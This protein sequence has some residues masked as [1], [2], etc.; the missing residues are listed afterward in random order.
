MAALDFPNS[1]TIGQQY[2]APNG[3]TYQWDGVVWA[4]VPVGS[5]PPSGP[6]GGDLTGSY[7]NPTIKPSALPWTPSGATLTPTDPTKNVTIPGPSGGVTGVVMGTG[8][9]K[10]RVQYSN[11]APGEFGLFVNRDWN[12]ANAQDDATRP[13][14]AFQI[15]SDVNDQLLVQRSPAG[16]TTQTALLMLD[17][18]GRLTLPGVPAPGDAFV[19]SSPSVTSGGAVHLGILNTTGGFSLRANVSL[20]NAMD[21]TS[22]TAWAIQCSP[23]TDSLLVYRSP[24]G[25]TPTFTQ[26]FLLDNGGNLTINGAT[27]TKASGTTWAN[28]SDR[29]LKDDIE[30]YATGLAAILQ[31][32]PRTFLYNGKG[33]STAGMRGYGFIADEIA[34]VMPETVGVRA[35]KLD[36]ADEDETDIQTLDQS[37]LI[38]A[39]VNA[40]K[41]LAARV[42]ALEAR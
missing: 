32:Q 15:R 7:P 10:G 24:A 23:Q 20:A 38:L 21:D 13:S 28:P 27:A 39:L 1:P 25:A 40:V 5:A 14:W 8:T 31:L 19:L 33:G 36:A 16:S 42:A 26:L 30:D 9:I 11:V 18:T 3:A 2:A 34:P 12:N 22:K 41:E 35:G 17:N 4:V 6:A 29:R 37:N